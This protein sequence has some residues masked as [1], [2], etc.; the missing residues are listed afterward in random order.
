[1]DSTCFCFNKAQKSKPP[2]WP[3]PAS[4]L[5]PPCGVLVANPHR[6]LRCL[7]TWQGFGSLRTPAL[8]AASRRCGSPQ[9]AAWDAAELPHPAPGAG[10]QK[11]SGT[12][13]SQCQ[14]ITVPFL[15]PFGFVPILG[16]PD[17]E[18]NDLFSSEGGFSRILASTFFITLQ[19]RYSC[20]L[21]LLFF[22]ILNVTV[23]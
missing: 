3:R 8:C 19:T 10:G 17:V 22:V 21:L 1:M 18:E 14:L 15:W 13:T 7:Q 6:E 11:V 20:V 16:L 5:Y 2:V 23:D 12:S 4:L 9:A